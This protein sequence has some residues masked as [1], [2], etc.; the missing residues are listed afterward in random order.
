MRNRHSFAPHLFSKFQR[1]WKFF[2]DFLVVRNAIPAKVWA[3]SAKENG[4]GTSAPPSGMLLDFLRECPL[5][6]AAT[7]L[8]FS[9][10]RRGWMHA[11]CRGHRIPLET[12]PNQHCFVLATLASVDLNLATTASGGRIFLGKGR[13]E[14]APC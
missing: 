2:P 10:K 14:T 8:S 5:R 13:E 1:C 9:D 6:P 3:L 7:F 11:T 4:A 12:P